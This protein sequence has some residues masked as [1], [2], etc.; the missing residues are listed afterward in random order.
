[1]KRL[2]LIGALYAGS[3][4]AA[5]GSPFSDRPL[6]FSL[7]VVDTE[8]ALDYGGTNVDTTLQRISIGWRERYGE[9]L[10]LGLVGGPSYLTQRNNAATAGLELNG[11]HAAVSLDIGLYASPGARVDFNATYLYQRVDHD[12]AGQKV[13]ID[14]REPSAQLSAGAGLG[15]GLW[16]YAGARYGRI[17]GEQRRSGVQNETRTIARNAPAGALIGLE[18]RLE[19]DG[20]IGLTGVSGV[21]RG[22][23]LYFGRRY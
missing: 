16:V 11:Y 1:M 23:A 19:H 18:L 13:V 3:A 10:Q 22:V 4:I 8:L 9:R 20:Y 15:A 6:D 12:N 21:D 5:D 7:R 2:A 17:D 14:W